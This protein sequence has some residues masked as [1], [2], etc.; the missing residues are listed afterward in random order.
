MMELVSE[1]LVFAAKAHDTMRRRSGNAPYILH[2]MEA[3]AIVG[4]MTDDQEIIA[5]AILHDVVEDAGI[6]MEE[7]EQTFGK[8]VRTL[9]GCET[10]S[11]REDLP[12]EDT[13]LVRKQ[14][15]L[16]ILKEADDPA[17]W[18]LWIGDKLSNMRAFYRTWKV[19]GEAMW[20]KFHQSDPAVQAW[21]YT[22]IAELTKPLSH[23]AAWAEYNALTN[24]VFGKDEPQ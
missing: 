20:K 18:M 23:T 7:I 11:K 17:V 21:Y 12:P 19:E 22:T 1:A 13:W 2:P 5:A 3:A 16:Q 4:T 14:E 6:T 24:I 10:E 9:V 8:R 15:T